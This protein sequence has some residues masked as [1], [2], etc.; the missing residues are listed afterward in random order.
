MFIHAKT[1]NALLQACISIPS[2]IA[3]RNASGMESTKV[4]NLAITILRP[5]FPIIDDSEKMTYSSGVLVEEFLMEPV[6][7]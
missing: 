2:G 6:R 4:K 7:M 1:L 3:K 5:L